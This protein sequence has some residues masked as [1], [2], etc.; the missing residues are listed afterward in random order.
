MV[1]GRDDKGLDQV[2]AMRMMEE[3]DLFSG[4]VSFF[5]FF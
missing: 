3:V 4:F 1:Q 5:F 2:A